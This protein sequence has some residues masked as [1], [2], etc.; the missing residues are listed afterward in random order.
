M[1]EWRREEG[2][3]VGRGGEG[4]EGERRRETRGGEEGKEEKGGE[5]SKERRKEGRGKRGGLCHMLVLMLS[6]KL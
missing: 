4:R 2:R 1:G 5:G 3:G 6:C